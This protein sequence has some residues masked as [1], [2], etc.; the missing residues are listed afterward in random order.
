M[1]KMRTF[2]FY[3]GDDV[4]TTEA[5]SY[6]KAVKS[7]QGSAKNKVVRVEWI[8]KKGGLYEILQSLPMGRSK[9]IGR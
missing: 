4:K 7:Y 6:K 1:S 9:K 5:V 8:A 2:T 3:D